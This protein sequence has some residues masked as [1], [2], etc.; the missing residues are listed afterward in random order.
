MLAELETVMR[1][2]QD[3]EGVTISGGEPFDQAPAL[4]RFAHGVREQGLTTLVY[5]GRVI[6]DLLQ[7]GPEGA[8]ELI[9]EI[10]ILLDGPFVAERL[11]RDLPWVGSD[12]QR[13]ILTSNRY[14][15]EQIRS[16][17]AR[18]GVDVVR[19]GDEVHVSGATDKDLVQ[20]ILHRL[21]MA[22]YGEKGA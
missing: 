11:A 12:N 21:R 6:E 13:I 20:N 7:S 8:S 17:L 10:D 5:T 3:L 16:T 15:P 19:F 4:V 9:H 14:S 22:G 18:I 1:N 2:N